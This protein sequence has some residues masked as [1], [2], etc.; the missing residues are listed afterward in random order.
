MSQKRKDEHGGEP[1]HW[2]EVRFVSR[3]QAVC[4]RTTGCN[5][6]TAAEE[7]ESGRI[8]ARLL[9]TTIEAQP[10]ARTDF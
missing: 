4:R 1:R 10:A 3:E 6:S 8:S 2:I 9:R 7:Q 5:A